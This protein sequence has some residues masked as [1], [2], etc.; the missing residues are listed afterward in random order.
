MSKEH[1]TREVRPDEA[2][3]I[4]D[5]EEAHENNFSFSLTEVEQATC[6]EW[7]KTH[8]TECRIRDTDTAIGGRWSFN[9]SKTTLGNVCKVSCACGQEKNVT[10]Y[11]CW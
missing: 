2:G 8:D 4:R 10:D 1:E 11:G 6:K 3:A 9:F 5:L 7:M